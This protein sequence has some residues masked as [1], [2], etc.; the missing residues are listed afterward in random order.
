MLLE[1][2]YVSLSPHISKD[3]DSDKL[4]YIYLA[5]YPSPFPKSLCLAPKVLCQAKVQID[6]F[7]NLV[8]VIFI[9][10]VLKGAVQNENLKTSRIQVLFKNF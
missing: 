9:F 2:V 4:C 10:L 7:H 8:T 6:L 1:A 5:N 3:I